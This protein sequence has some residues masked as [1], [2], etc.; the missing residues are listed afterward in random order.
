MLVAFFSN[1][2]LFPL[3]IACNFGKEK[4]YIV[5]IDR[6]EVAKPSH[7]LLQTEIARDCNY[8]LR[9]VLQSVRWKDAST[10]A[11]ICSHMP[12][13]NYTERSNIAYSFYPIKVIYCNE[14][15]AAKRR[16]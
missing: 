14:V 16:A 1:N 4:S 7:K 10:N 2:K 11:T 15:V 9:Q 6:N 3:Y 13:Q 12:K 8:F 5:A